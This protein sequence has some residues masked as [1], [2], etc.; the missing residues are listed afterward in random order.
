MYTLKS[1]YVTNDTPTQDVLDQIDL[2]IATNSVIILVFHGFT[3]EPGCGNGHR[4][5][6]DKFKDIVGYIYEMR[7]YI[8]VST[9]QE[10]LSK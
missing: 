6:I 4:I 3:P 7:D 9:F 2:A 10:L 1:I 5:T 8:T